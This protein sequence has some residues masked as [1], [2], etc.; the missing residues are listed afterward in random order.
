MPMTTA[1]FGYT[2][3]WSHKNDIKKRFN[4]IKKANKEIVHVYC[5]V[6]L[7]KVYP[8]D[9]VY[10]PTLSIKV[11]INVDITYTLK[12]FFSYIMARTC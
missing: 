2:R 9:F 4:E 6:K 11:L 8:N 5:M 3:I 12:Q 10:T 7:A 1:L